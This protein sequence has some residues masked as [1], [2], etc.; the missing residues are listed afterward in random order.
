MQLHFREQGH[1]PVVIILHGLFGSL[2]NWAYVS[3]QLAERFRIFSLDQRNHGQSPHTPEMNYR[4][5]AGDLRDFMQQHGLSSAA[6]MGH[7]M[8][9]KAAM[10]FALT[11][12]GMVDRLVVV[13][14]APRSYPRRHDGLFDAL[15]AVDLRNF[16][17]RG[18]VDEAL[19]PSIP[20]AG[21]RRFLLKSLAQTSPGVFEWRFNLPVLR[22]HYPELTK[23]LEPG[24]R[25]DRP[26]LFIRGEKSDYVRAEDIAGIHELFP[27]AKIE[28]IAGASHWVHA[29][30]AEKF[31]SVVGNFLGEN[32]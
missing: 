2:D 4:L 23:A 3:Q 17:T 28:T 12:P 24:R 18:Q 7:S 21:V 6:M 1:G 31:V 16:R 11:W 8:G 22:D 19:A 27:K 10:E 30:S 32:F 15:L 25:C 26:A 5:L 9:G 13:D 14:M 29:E 20:E